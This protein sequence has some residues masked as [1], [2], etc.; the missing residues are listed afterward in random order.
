MI[1]RKAVQ[2]SARGSHEAHKSILLFVRINVV[3]VV[4]TMKN[5]VF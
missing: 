3:L 2:L 5:A 4:V 1:Y